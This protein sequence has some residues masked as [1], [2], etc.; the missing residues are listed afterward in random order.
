MRCYQFAGHIAGD[1]ERLGNGAPLRNEAGDIVGRGEIDS[2]VELFD[3]AVEGVFHR[4][5]P[6]QR[7]KIFMSG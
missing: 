7:E 3:V 6:G 4:W 5:L 2:L 1:F